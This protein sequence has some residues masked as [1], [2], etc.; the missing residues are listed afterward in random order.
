MRSGN[1]ILQALFVLLC[2]GWCQAADAPLQENHPAEA[3]LVSADAE[4]AVVKT[5]HPGAKY[6]RSPFGEYFVSDIKLPDGSSCQVL[7]FH[8]GWGKVSAAASTQYVIDRWNPRCLINLGTCG[9]FAGSVERGTIVLAE[10]TIIHDIIERM[11]NAEA[12]INDYITDID[13]G[14]LEGS[15]P[16]KVLRAP[17]VSADQDLDP[18]AIPALWTTYNAVAADWESGAI[19][20]VARKNHKRILILRG[21]T[22]LVGPKGG[23]AYG[24]IEVFE[25]ATKTIMKRLLADLPAWLSRISD[26]RDTHYA[27]FLLPGLA[28]YL[29][30]IGL[31]LPQALFFS[32]RLE[33]VDL[34]VFG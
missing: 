5:A 14:W 18:K 32:L 7:F 16:V 30:R 20:Y 9:G 28:H 25:R 31:D 3:V 22:D 11:G 10:R 27:P 23:E 24:K 13:L 2:C 21:V 19:A 33:L 12:A 4:W 1:K 15:P 17:L 26:R 6:D 34:V 29:R 8:G